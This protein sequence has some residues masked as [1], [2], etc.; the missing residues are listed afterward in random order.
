M[1]KFCGLIRRYIVS[2]FLLKKSLLLLTYE[3]KRFSWQPERHQYLYVGAY[4]SA[5]PADQSVYI[6]GC[7]YLFSSARG[8]PLYMPL[9]SRYFKGSVCDPLT[10]ILLVFCQICVCY[11]MKVFFMQT[12][13]V[14]HKLDDSDQI[15]DVFLL[16]RE[17]IVTAY[18]MRTHMNTHGILIQ[19]VKNVS[20]SDKVHRNP[21]NNSEWPFQQVEYFTCVALS[22]LW[23]SSTG[24][25]KYIKS[26]TDVY[27]LIS[28]S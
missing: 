4:K 27:R 18:G 14:T 10:I 25:R 17:T 22:N 6:G 21:H 16:L 23:D 8:I 15:Y 2:Y 1:F 9:P 12:V 3:N 26:T 20:Q 7:F 28:G 5:V 11:F 24:R 13:W 19:L